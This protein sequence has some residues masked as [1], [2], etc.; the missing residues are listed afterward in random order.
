MLESTWVLQYLTLE[1]CKLKNTWIWLVPHNT[2]ALESSKQNDDRTLGPTHPSYFS[3][4][5]GKFIIIIIHA[6]IVFRNKWC[7]FEGNIFFPFVALF[8]LLLFFHLMFFEISYN[9]KEIYFLLVVKLLQCNSLDF[10]R[11]DKSLDCLPTFDHYQSYHL[12]RKS[13]SNFVKR[14]NI[15]LIDSF[16]II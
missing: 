5:H 9:L 12:R 14:V 2:W 13:V 6:L 1:T 4:N 10:T 16:S 15:S 11:F 7:C 3:H 8:L